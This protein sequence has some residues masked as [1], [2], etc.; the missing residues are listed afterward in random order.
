MICSVYSCEMSGTDTA[1]ATRRDEERDQQRRFS[2]RRLHR[3]WSAPLMA[4][5]LSMLLMLALMGAALRC[6]GGLQGTLTRPASSPS[7]WGMAASILTQS[8]APGQRSALCYARATS[9]PV[10]MQRCAPTWYQAAVSGIDVACGSTRWWKCASSPS[11]A[12]LRIWYSPPPCPGSEGLGSRIESLG[13]RGSRVRGKSARV[14]GRGLGSECEGRGVWLAHS[15][16][17]ILTPTGLP[18]LC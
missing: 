9:C 11:E 14:E 15:A 5:F 13:S 12:A 17:S 16:Q 2:S 7:S 8:F 10:L 3:C 6:G 18:A 4:V 1:C